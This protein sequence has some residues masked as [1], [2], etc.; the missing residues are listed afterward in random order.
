MIEKTASFLRELK[1]AARSLGR[2]KGVTLTV[3]LTLALGIG[4]NAVMFSLVRGVLLRPLTVTKIASSTSGRAR[5]ATTFSIPEIDA[6]RSHTKTLRSFGDFSTTGFTM[7]GD[8][9]TSLG[10]GWD[11]GQILFPGDGTAPG[12]RSAGSV[13]LTYRFW[14]IA[15]NTDPS[16]LATEPEEMNELA[17]SR[18][19]DA[20]FA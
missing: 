13:V 2:A 20:L 10:P 9:R 15:L 14:S 5:K 6:L 19:V 8:R 3:V 18:R 1:V 12:A 17:N 4:A 16:V 7:V 11:S